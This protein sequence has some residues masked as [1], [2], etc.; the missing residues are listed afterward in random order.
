MISLNEQY[1][2][3]VDLLESNCRGFD[4]RGDLCGKAD[5]GLSK[6]KKKYLN[7]IQYRDKDVSSIKSNLTYKCL[8]YISD[9]ESLKEIHLILINVIDELKDA[10][11]CF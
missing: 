8:S 6:N 3:N 2:W 4:N 7:L 10:N 5:F 11:I 1:L 9:K